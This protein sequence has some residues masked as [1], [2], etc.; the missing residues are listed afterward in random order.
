MRIL[1]LSDIHANWTALQA[2]HHAEPEFDACLILG[3]LVDFGPQ[4]DKVIE[5]ARQNATLVIRGNH[6]QS[7]AQFIQPHKNE[8]MWHRLRNYSRILHWQNLSAENLDYLSRLPVRKYWTCEDGRFLLIHATPFDPLHEYSMDEKAFW[9]LR[10]QGID[11]NFVCIGHTHRPYGESI[12]SVKLI[13]PGS[14]GQQK[15]GECVANYVVIQDGHPEFRQIDF[16]IE[17]LIA[18]F[19]AA[20]FEQE[21]QQIARKVYTKGFTLEDAGIPKDAG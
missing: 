11:A 8:T 12:G 17:E 3:D 18:E 15:A 5:W 13:N 14:V 7:V 19:E 10:L 6:D 4:P 9:K 1:L 16:D 2:V 21:M 20:G